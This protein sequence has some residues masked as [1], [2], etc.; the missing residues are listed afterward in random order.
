VR[1][2]VGA[3]GVGSI[4]VGVV[5]VLGRSSMATP[6]PFLLLSPGILTGAFAPDSGFG[7]K[8]DTHP[9]GPISTVI[10]YGVNMGLYSGLAYLIIRAIRR[11]RKRSS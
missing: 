4:F 6:I 11:F 2:A 10:L 1:T 3:F 9:W 7:P 8:G 5:T